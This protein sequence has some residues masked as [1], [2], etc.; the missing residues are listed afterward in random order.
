MKKIFSADNPLRAR[1]VAAMLDEH[2]ISVM[3]QGDILWGARGGLPLTPDAAPS[4]WVTDDE[5]A[6]RAR[7]LVAEF[8]Q[9]VN[10][11]HCTNCGYNLRGLPKPRCPECGKSFREEHPRT[12]PTCGELHEGQFTHCWNCG[13]ALEPAEDE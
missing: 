9:P 13:N 8:D 4:V 10:P 12:C 1:L 2:G 5:D 6:A 7:E 3:I 11:T